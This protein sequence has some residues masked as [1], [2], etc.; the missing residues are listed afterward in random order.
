MRVYVGPSAPRAIE[1]IITLHA[2][3]GWT[4]AYTLTQIE[5]SNRRWSTHRNQHI[6]TKD[7]LR[8]HG[9]NRGKMDQAA[10]GGNAWLVLSWPGLGAQ[11]SCGAHCIITVEHATTT[12]VRR[13]EAKG[14]GHA[15]QFE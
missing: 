4:A 12:T 3:V 10:N 14:R 15:C 9:Q 8:H 7:T 6:S 1:S 5:H 11:C 13:N 2:G